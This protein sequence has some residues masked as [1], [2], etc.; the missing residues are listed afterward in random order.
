ME[1]PQRIFHNLFA[2]VKNFKREIECTI[3]YKRITENLK[4]TLT[5]AYLAFVAFVS[6]DFESFLLIFKRKES[7]IHILYTAMGSF[8]A[9]FLPSLFQLKYL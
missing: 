8:Q 4:S 5:P 6:Q 1:D 3:R 9:K 2:T 7:M